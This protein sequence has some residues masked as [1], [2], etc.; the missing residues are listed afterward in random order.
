L[1][2][3]VVVNDVTIVVYCSCSPPALL[4]LVFL[5]ALALGGR[6]TTT[7]QQPTKNMQTRWRGIIQDM[8][9]DGDMEGDHTGHEF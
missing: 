1:A 4:E 5:Y 8:N 9:S 7:Q 3:V 2:I 6:Q